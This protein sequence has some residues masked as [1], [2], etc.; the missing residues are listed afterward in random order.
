MGEAEERPRAPPTPVKANE[1]EFLVFAVFAGGD[2]T[3]IVCHEPKVLLPPPI[4]AVEAF[5]LS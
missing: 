1:T 5:I 2:R 4:A 3:F